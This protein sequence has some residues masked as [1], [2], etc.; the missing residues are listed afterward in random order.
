LLC[1]AGGYAHAV[2]A[3]TGIM[4]AEEANDGV[5]RVL[6][7]GLESALALGYSTHDADEANRRYATAAEASRWEQC[8]HTLPD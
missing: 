4:I 6:L 7:E 2:D 1:V 8:I 3:R 5:Y